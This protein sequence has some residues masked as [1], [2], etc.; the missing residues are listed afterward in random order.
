MAAYVLPIIAFAI[1][2]FCATQSDTRGSIRRPT[3]DRGRGPAT[4]HEVTSFA[5][6]V[7]IAR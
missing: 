5:A 3:R 1:L 4:S 7:S 6:W 2:L